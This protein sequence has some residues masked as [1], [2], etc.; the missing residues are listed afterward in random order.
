M[1]ANNPVIESFLNFILGVVFLVFYLSK[2]SK[3]AIFSLICL[4]ILCCDCHIKII[5]PTNCCAVNKLLQS[6]IQNWIHETDK[7]NLLVSFKILSNGSA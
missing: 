4:Q 1:T 7:L 6:I 2:Y 3:L 5:F